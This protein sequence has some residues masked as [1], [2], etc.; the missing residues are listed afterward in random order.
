MNRNG[1]A[2]VNIDDQYISKVKIRF[3]KIT[4][5]FNKDAKYF[6]KKYK[7]LK[8]YVLEI[9][10]KII[11]LPKNLQ[12][13]EKTIL[14]AYAV[15]KEIGISHSD[16]NKYIN[17]FNLP[18]GRGKS[19]KIKKNIVLIDDCYN[20]NPASVLLAINRFNDF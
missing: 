6:A 5:G 8:N 16:I 12:H 19:I 17:T 14:S 13:L 10:N 3:N 4:F 18:D 11:S 2:F 9:N 1:I 15:S 20:A 7:K